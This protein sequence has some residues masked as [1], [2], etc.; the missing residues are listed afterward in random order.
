MEDSTVRAFLQY[1]YKLSVSRIYGVY[2][3]I[4]SCVLIYTYVGPFV[5]RV[6]LLLAEKRTF[7]CVNAKRKF[8]L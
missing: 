3:R 1:T 4:R 5:W 7:S 2:V 6:C 8:N